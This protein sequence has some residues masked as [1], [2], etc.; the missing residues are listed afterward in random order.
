MPG[1]EVLNASGHTGLYGGTEK[2]RVMVLA[3][4][5]GDQVCMAP[6]PA[7]QVLGVRRL[8]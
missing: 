6:F 3:G 8:A 5:Q 7:A 2:D 1:P 4:N